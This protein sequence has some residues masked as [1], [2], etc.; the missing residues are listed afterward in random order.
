MSTASSGPVAMIRPL[1]SIVLKNSGRSTGWARMQ[2]HP[3]NRSPARGRGTPARGTPA[4]GTFACPRR[5]RFPPADR[6]N[7]RRREQEADRIGDHGRDRAEEPDRDPAQWRPDHGGCPGRGLQAPV[8]DEQ[9]LRPHQRLDGGAAGRL[10]G[11]IG[12][13]GDDRHDQELDEAE[14]AERERGG[15]AHHRGAPGQV[16]RH[17]HR[18]LAAELHPRA[19]RHRRH[20][21]HRHPRRGQHRHRG[22]SGV[23][24]HDRDQGKGP[25]RQ[26]RAGHADHVRRPEPPELPPERPPGHHVRHPSPSHPDHATPTGEI[27][28]HRIWADQTTTAPARHNRALSN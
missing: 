16:H 27:K 13:P 12:G 19:Q 5:A 28:A 18:P 24:H 8:R 21:P 6:V 11:D 20:R 2:R 22:R 15:D 23:Q 7:P 9:V 1:T 10:E 3:P 26:G 14:P 4:R 17:H 25:E